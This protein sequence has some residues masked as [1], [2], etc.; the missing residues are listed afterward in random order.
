M[1]ARLALLNLTS[2]L[3]P[4][5]LDEPTNHLDVEMI[6]ALEDALQARGH[7]LF[8]SHDRRFLEALHSVWEV[9]SG[10][11]TK[12]GG[13]QLLPP[14]QGT[15]QVSRTIGLVNV[16]VRQSRPLQPNLRSAAAPAKQLGGA[17]SWRSI[18]SAEADQPKWCRR[19]RPTPSRRHDGHDAAAGD[20]P[21][22]TQAEILAALGSKHAALEAGLLAL[23]EE[24]HDVTERLSAA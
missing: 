4:P 7:A 24:W 23:M 22:P 16:V 19:R 17:E 6:T 12:F 10:R 2:A 5:G 20:G 14:S 1:S 21:P 13:D 11:F 15:P 8:V 18:A 3:Q 9:D